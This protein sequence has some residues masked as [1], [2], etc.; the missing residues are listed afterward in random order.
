MSNIS[1]AAGILLSLASL[2]AI[3]AHAASTCAGFIPGSITTPANLRD[4]ID[5]AQ[6]VNCGGPDTIDLGGNTI[7]F[8]SADFTYDGEAVAL[9]MVTTPITIKNGTVTR[10]AAAGFRFLRVGAG[11]ALALEQMTVSNGGGGTI[12]LGGAV[13]LEDTGTLTVT[14]TT[15]LNNSAPGYGGGAI[16]ATGSGTLTVR[17]SVFRGNV[18]VEGAAILTQSST[19][20]QIERTQFLGNTGS[21]TLEV[22]STGPA[23]IRDSLFA[24][25]DGEAV[26]LISGASPVFINTTIA[27]NSGDAVVANGSVTAHVFRNMLIWGN[28]G[29]SFGGTPPEEVTYSAAEDYADAMINSGHTVEDFFVTPLVGPTAANTGANYNP[30]LYDWTLRPFS[31]AIDQG[32]S[33]YAATLDLNNAPR[34]VEDTP[35]PDGPAGVVDLGAYERQTGSCTSFSFPYTVAS[36]AGESRPLDLRDAIRCAN[37]NGPGLDVI[38]I[39]PGPHLSYDNPFASYDGT[40]TALPQITSQI[41]IVGDGAT[42]IERDGLAGTPQ[43]GLFSVGASGHLMLERVVLRNGDAGTAVGR[44]GGAIHVAGVLEVIDSSLENNSAYRGGAISVAGGAL[45][46]LHRSTLLDNNATDRGG[47]IDGGGTIQLLNSTLTGNTAPAGAA[48]FAN[49]IETTLVNTTIS[50]N[51]GGGSTAAVA[52]AAGTSRL[53]NNILANNAPLDCENSGGTFNPNGVAPNL[54]EQNSAMLPCGAAANTITSDPLLGTLTGSPAYFPLASAESPA[55]N[56]GDNM[57]TTGSFDQRGTGFL[58]IVGGRV[59]L[60]SFESAFLPQE[61]TLQFAATSSSAAEAAGFGNLLRVTTSDGNAT[62][63][64]TTVTVSVTGGT[65]G[66]ADYTGAGTV[67]V[68]AGTAHGS[69]VSIGSG[70]QVVNDSMVEP[71]ETVVLTLTAPASSGP[72]VAALGAQTT[73][74]HTITNDDT[75]SVTLQDVSQTEGNAGTSTMTF[76]AT[77]NNAVQGGFTVNWATANGTATFA[78]GDYMAASGTLTFL[79]IAGEIHTLT[80]M[81]NGDTKLEPDETFTVSMSGVSNAAVNVSDTATGTIVSDEVAGYVVDTSST[82][83]IPEPATST[84]FTIALTAI[85]SGTVM[86]DFASTDA[87]ECSV[88]PAAITFDATNALSPQTITIS[89]VDDLIADGTQPCAITITRSGGTATE[90]A[91]AANPA[92]VAVNVTDDDVSG[93]SITPTLVSVTEGGATASYSVVLQSEPTGD[94]S[95]AVSGDAQATATPASLLFTPADW[96]VAQTVTVTAVDDAVAEGAHTATITHAA[97]GADY[98]GIAVASVSVDIAD[99][100]APGFLV[101]PV[102]GLVTTEAGGTASFTVVLQTEPAADVT[103]TLASSDTGEGTVSPAS[104]LFTAANW[105]EPQTVTVTGVD[106]AVVDG[107]IAYRIIPAAASSADPDYDGLVAAEVALTNLDDDSVTLTIVDVSQAEGN[108]DNTAFVFTVALSGEVAGGVS[109][110]WTTID[111]SA[112]SPD[113]YAAASGTLLFDGNDGETRSITVQVAGDTLVEPDEQFRVQLSAVSPAT[114]VLARSEATGTIV[115]DDGG[116]LLSASKRVTQAGTTSQPVIYEIV[117]ANTG[118]HDQPDDPA[119]DELV[120][121]LPASLSLEEATATGGT[122]TT[123]GNTVRWNGALAAGASVTL[124]IQAQVLATQPGP[125][126]SQAQIA[127]DSDGDGSNDASGVSDD[128]DTA[129]PDDATAFIFAGVAPYAIPTLGL[130]TLFWLALGIALLGGWT[131]RRKGA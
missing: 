111:G 2:F 128:P 91:S 67:T 88:S 70:L 125:I 6:S 117:L 46:T 98:D 23:Q 16:L 50:G 48:L 97:S 33:A 27:G 4:A 26:Y 131:L 69:L 25:N 43:F 49:G 58:R 51:T 124:Q 57:F 85:P 37:A 89:A 38:T 127:W 90:F 8:T 129:A 104:L 121:V 79:G 36:S 34:Q 126:S 1:R 64:A 14:R 63:A 118:A 47:A 113:D 59:D 86:L 5:A 102:A 32:E 95:I 115:N 13:H 44:Q 108:A 123:A 41:R 10:S 17:D 112:T 83:D 87:T 68:P 39:A 120:D 103:L 72:V 66:A 107:D 11:G 45:L 12:T 116:A 20:L 53:Y 62:R 3:P 24:G 35:V 15:F 54:I 71:D 65:A 78:D 109:V 21:G 7:T 80:V 119:S 31:P 82:T 92:N 60:G 76:T 101:T 56:A 93:V 9:P 77:L 100:D 81:I 84:S 61:V 19:T 73:T 18:A 40:P 52:L 29:R 122:L 94:V 106:D 28:S 99:N 96:N 42:W 74:T 22:S 114:V 30:A 130:R 110:D 75:A 55:A 105:N